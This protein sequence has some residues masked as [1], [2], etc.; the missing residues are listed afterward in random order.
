MKGLFK[1]SKDLYVSFHLERLVNTSPKEYQLSVNDYRTLRKANTSIY[2]TFADDLTI[3]I[4]REEKISIRLPKGSYELS[5]MQVQ[6]EDYRLLQKAVQSE[7]KS[8]GKLDWNGGSTLRAEVDNSI[9]N[10]YLILPVPFEKGW[11]A[12]VNGKKQ[13]ILQANYA[14]TALPLE[15]GLNQVEMQYRP[16]YFLISLFLSLCGIAIAW[17]E[18]IRRRRSV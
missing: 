5:N 8:P 12:T 14:F 13:P 16:P 4:P 10:S 15:K 3:R 2:R 9:G 1:Q 11:Q 18:V 17:I 6:G 7:G